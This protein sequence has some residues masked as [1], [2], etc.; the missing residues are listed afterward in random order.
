MID[1]YDSR[2]TNGQSRAMT[3]FMAEVPCDSHSFHAF[4]CQ[5][6]EQRMGMTVTHTPHAT[7]A[8]GPSSV[9]RPA[10]PRNPYAKKAFE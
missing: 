10:L 1:V 4:L 9:A 3:D 6:V 7:T 8:S 2:K 5:S